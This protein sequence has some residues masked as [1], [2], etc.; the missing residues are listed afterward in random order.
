MSTVLPATSSSLAWD[1]MSFV[2]RRHG[3]HAAP[4]LSEIDTRAEMAKVIDAHV[5]AQIPTVLGHPATPDWCAAV[6]EHH[7]ST[8]EYVY[9][10]CAATGQVGP[11]WDVDRALAAVQAA[12]TPPLTVT[13]PSASSPL[14]S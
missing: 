2:I 10:F 1:L 8:E 11:P 5:A 12:F 14:P 7:R 3:A 13:P 4:H 9:A 6:D